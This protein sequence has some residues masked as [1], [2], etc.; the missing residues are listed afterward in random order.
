MSKKYTVARGNDSLGCCNMVIWDFLVVALFAGLSLSEYLKLHP[1]FCVIAGIAAG[2]LFMFLMSL[3][4][5]GIVLKVICSLFWSYVI[6]YLLNDLFKM[7]EKLGSDPI[8][9]WTIR[10]VVFLLCLGIHVAGMQK[11]ADDDSYDYQPVDVERMRNNNLSYLNSY[12]NEEDDKHFQDEIKDI[13]HSVENLFNERNEIM[14][15]AQQVM[16]AG[17]GSRELELAMKRNNEE[18]PNKSEEIQNHMQRLN[19][20]VPSKE[21]TKIILDLR[22]CI[23][24][25]KTLNQYV[26]NE[27]N[28]VL[29]DNSSK[30]QSV[31]LNFDESLFSG[32]QDKEGLTKRYRSLMKTFH[33]DN[34]NG[35]IKMTQKIQ[36]T[37]EELTKML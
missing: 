26:M 29:L 4:Y 10:I 21:G 16:I 12:E 7:T 31:D 37:Y 23:D 8:W 13:I 3:K 35:D 15:Q 22:K 17:V 20:G 9:L 6:L 18:C 19:V 30:N 28:K 33:P 24:S 1:V 32:C 11:I 14:N 2:G 36:H 25:I 5:I 34:E 27:L